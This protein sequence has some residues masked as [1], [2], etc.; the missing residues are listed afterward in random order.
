MSKVTFGFGLSPFAAVLY[1]IY[2]LFGLV[3]VF[4]FSFYV[5]VLCLRSINTIERS[6]LHDFCHLFFLHC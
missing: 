2:E 4:S 6:V 3:N 1:L 5:N